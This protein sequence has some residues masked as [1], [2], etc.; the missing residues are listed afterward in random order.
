MIELYSRHFSDLRRIFESRLDKGD[1]SNI[2][3]TFQLSRSIASHLRSI[4]DV[5]KRSEEL[6]LFT[7]ARSVYEACVDL[8]LSNEDSSY[9]DSLARQATQNYAILMKYQPND[10]VLSSALTEQ[11]KA[12]L[13]QAAKEEIMKRHKKNADAAFKADSKYFAMYS[14]CT[15]ISH[16]N[17]VTLRDTVNIMM[18]VAVIDWIKSVLQETVVRMEKNSL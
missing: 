18:F 11:Q 7:L 10:S 16:G 15:F 14:Y 13:E 6:A 2:D 12:D 5:L 8:V 17:V 3:V 1:A 9:V 4:E